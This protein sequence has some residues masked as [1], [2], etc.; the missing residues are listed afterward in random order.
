MT[1]QT[2]R[3]QATGQLADLTPAL[4]RQLLDEQPSAFR[5]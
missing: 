4:E 5:T 1:A 3:V 2:Y